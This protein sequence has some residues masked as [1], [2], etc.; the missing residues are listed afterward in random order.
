MI[1]AFLLAQSPRRI[2]SC[3]VWIDSARVGTARRVSE[4]GTWPSDENS[5]MDVCDTLGIDEGV[6]TG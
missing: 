5:I 3:S 2:G 4:I 1:V 6:D